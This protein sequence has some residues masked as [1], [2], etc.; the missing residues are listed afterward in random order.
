MLIIGFTHSELIHFKLIF[1]FTGL[2][3]LNR[4]NNK[5]LWLY[6]A[7][8]QCLSEYA[9]VLSSLFENYHKVCIFQSKQLTQNFTFI[10]NDQRK[11]YLSSFKGYGH[12]FII[13]Q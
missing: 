10:L 4:Y 1:R 13:E 11:K 2:C 7:V 8:V 12:C 3:V 6:T 9:T 5:G